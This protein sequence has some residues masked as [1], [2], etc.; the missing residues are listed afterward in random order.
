M[1]TNVS[2]LKFE[3]RMMAQEVISRLPSMGVTLSVS[4]GG[5]LALDGPR[6]ALTPEVVESVR[7]HKE[8]LIGLLKPVASP[9]GKAEEASTVCADDFVHEVLVFDADAQTPGPA[10]LEALKNWCR[11]HAL[12]DDD[13]RWMEVAKV[14]ER[15]GC[16][17]KLAVWS[18]VRLRD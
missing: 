14:L 7:T 4:E 5:N 13:V 18:G 16:S 10:L 15:H 17:S 8:E 1:I 3:V 6:G 11:E 12:A 2:G 9:E